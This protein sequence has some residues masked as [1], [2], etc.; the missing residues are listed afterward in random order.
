MSAIVGEFLEKLSVTCHVLS[1][2]GLVSE[3]VVVE[4]LLSLSCRVGKL[5]VG[6]LS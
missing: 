4:K 3:L 2:S 6:E 5:S 1:A